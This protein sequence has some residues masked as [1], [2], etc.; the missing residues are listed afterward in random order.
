MNPSSS[1]HITL[2]DALCLLFLP[3]L[4]ARSKN[5]TFVREAYSSLPPKNGKPRKCMRRL[6]RYCFLLGSMRGFN[7]QSVL[8]QIALSIIRAMGT[9]KKEVPEGP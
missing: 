7:K 1:Y 3:S 4:L 2:H 6:L 8:M 9:P 5:K